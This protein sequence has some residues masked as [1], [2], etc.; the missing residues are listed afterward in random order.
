MN[1]LLTEMLTGYNAC[2]EIVD[3]ANLLIVNSEEVSCIN[4]ININ[5]QLT[6]PLSERG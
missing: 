4:S 1:R 6:P 2:N 5:F 3:C